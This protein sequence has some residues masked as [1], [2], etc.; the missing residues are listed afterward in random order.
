MVLN[1]QNTFHSI[2]I[3]KLFLSGMML[4]MGH[5]IWA[6]YPCNNFYSIV[7]SD[8]VITNAGTDDH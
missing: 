3:K 4:M 6:Q 7:G 1:T 2:M 8:A 5:F